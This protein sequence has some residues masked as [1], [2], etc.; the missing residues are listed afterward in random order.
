MSNVLTTSRDADGIL[1]VM[2]DVPGRPMNVLT[3]AFLAELDACIST[4]S[5]D[6]SLRGAIITSAKRSFIAGAD[7]MD[8]VNAYTDGKGVREAYESSHL[9]ND[10]FRRLETCGKPIVAAINGLALGGGFELCLA[11]HYRV[12]VSDERAVVGLPE[13]KLGLLPGGGG[14]QRVPRLI[15]IPE[16]VTL[17]T[18]GRQI[19]PAEAL[20]LG[21]VH[22]VVES[23]ELITHARRWLLDVGD[24]V[25]PWD[26]K[27]FSIPGGAGILNPAAYQTFTFGVAAI[28]RDT[29]ENLPAPIT[30]LAAVY[31]GTIVAIDA[32]L[33]IESSYFAQLLAGPVARNLM[34][35]MFVNK[36]R[37]DKLVRRPVGIDKST[38]R[39][40][41]VLGAGMMGSGIAYSAAIV[42]IEVVLLDTNLELA[43]KGKRYSADV[44]AKEVKKWRRT[45]AE[46]EIAL[47]RIHA[48]DSFNDLAACDLVVEAVFEKRE[49]KAEVT[50][51]TEAVVSATT[52]FASNTSTLP[53]SG[54]ASAS[55]RP[56]QFIGL[57]FFSPVEK[58]QLVEVI[59]GKQTSQAT[60]AHALD[61]VGQLRKTPIVVNDS[62]G[63][64]TSR[65]FAVFVHEGIRMLEEGVLPALIENGA[66]RAG[67]PVGPLAVSD[68][69]SIELL[70]K[71][72]AQ[73]EADLGAEYV[74][75]AGYAVV[76]RFVEELQR[77]GRRH[78]AGF[79]DY[80]AGRRKRLWPGL[81]K[82]YPRAPRQPSVEEVRKRILY[83]QAVESARCFE[84]GVVTQPADADLGS[85]LGW[86][87]P[88][89]TGGTLSL[90]ETIGLQQFVAECDQLARLHGGRFAVPAGL[91]ARAAK[92]EPY[93]PRVGDAERAA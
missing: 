23:A 18:D 25:Q 66:R 69:V 14:T 53:I 35:T 4:L 46:A 48:T 68:E 10:I 50:K 30:I 77:L 13:V 75:P 59:V 55:Q 85:I 16:A 1:T 67:M 5:N 91:R 60:L 26:K 40:L 15:G 28:A 81:A 47:Q 7:I 71:V 6:A 37:A 29:Q 45:S 39:R 22:A 56:D 88:T 32:A 31:E 41:G 89:W 83:I 34:R 19:P 63:F 87:F 44:L 86:A 79:Y 52:V 74:K 78:G 42:G 92:N 65:V 20:K 8:M 84:E 49:L 24:P 38:V 33:R 58:M 3:P 93:H 80:P 17:L 57:H 2:I 11:C 76:L 51:K 61:F 21:L 73:S 12:I 64:Y 82:L 9:V 90:I 72:I 43:E 62:R 70:R 27:G 54:L 36:G